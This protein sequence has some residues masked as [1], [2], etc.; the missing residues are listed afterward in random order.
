[1]NIKL[2]YRESHFNIDVMEDTPCQY[3]YRVAQKVFRKK[4]NDILLFY[5]KNR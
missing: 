3:L 4:Q 1:M 5:G 2:V